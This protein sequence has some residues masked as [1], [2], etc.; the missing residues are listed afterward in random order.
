MLRSDDNFVELVVSTFKWILEIKLRL[1]A[2]C[3]KC[4]YHLF[5]SRGIGDNEGGITSHGPTSV[6][7]T[8]LLNIIS[9]HLAAILSGLLLNLM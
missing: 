8:T 4:L 3:R 9:T 2:L 7:D 6:N 5:N 1:P